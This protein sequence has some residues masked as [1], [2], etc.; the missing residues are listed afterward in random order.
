M[1]LRASASCLRAAPMPIKGH[2]YVRNGSVYAEMNRLTERL[3]REV[4]KG[5]RDAVRVAALKK[6]L[7]ATASCLR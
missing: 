6:A 5:K 1:A 7:R 4:L 3:R 2:G